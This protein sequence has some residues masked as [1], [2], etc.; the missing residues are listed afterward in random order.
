MATNAERLLDTSVA[1]PFLLRSHAAHPV[2]FAEL[3]QDTRLGLAGHAVFETIS[4]LTRLPGNSR[5]S[6][7]TATRLVQQ[8]FPASRRLSAPAS[9]GVLDAIARHGISGGA[10]Y[11]ALVAAAALEHGCALVTRDRRALPTYTA[12]GVKVIELG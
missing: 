2:T 6:A 11:D 8:N 5:V 9:A 3:G 10:V 12:I 1:V 4:V 7:A